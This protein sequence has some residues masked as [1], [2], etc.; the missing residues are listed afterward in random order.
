MRPRLVNSPH[1]ALMALNRVN[2]LDVPIDAVTEQA[3]MERIRGFL[4]DGRQHLVTT[5][6]PEMLVLAHKDGRFRS[7]LSEAGLN[8][9]DGA[10]LLWAAKRRGTPLPAR[11]TGVDFT[12]RLAALAAQT[13]LRLFLLGAAPGIAERAASYLA[14]KYQG[15]TVVGAE[16]GGKMSR[17]SRG[18]FRLESDEVIGRIRNA[19]PD[20]LLAAFGH[21]RQEGWI[22]AHLAELPSVKVAMGIGGTFDYLAGTVP[23]ASGLMRHLGL[24]WLY[25]FWREPWRWRRMFD[26]L[27]V[28]PWLVWR[29]KT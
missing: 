27:I 19:A 3:A 6:N 9:P 17:D 15:L 22:V 21:G 18:I 23:R 10:G 28:F 25:R 8:L 14:R 7:I 11:V 20:I 13:G 1:T 24:E 4:S 26:A 5:P 29:S 2:I 16:S 12:E